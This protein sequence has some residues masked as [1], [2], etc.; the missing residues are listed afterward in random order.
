MSRPKRN[1]LYLLASEIVDV[2]EFAEQYRQEQLEAESAGMEIAM[3][4][5]PDPAHDPRFA[6]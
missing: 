5:Y 1:E 4:G 6:F 2:V 3:S